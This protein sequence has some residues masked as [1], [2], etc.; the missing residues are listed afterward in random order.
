MGLCLIQNILYVGGS[1]PDPESIRFI[2]LGF[3]QRKIKA[4]KKKPILVHLL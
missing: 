3:E 4:L 2:E 1:Q